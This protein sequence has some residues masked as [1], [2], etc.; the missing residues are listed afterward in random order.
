MDSADLQDESETAETVEV[1]IVAPSGAV[2]VTLPLSI[3]VPA[4][5]AMKTCLQ[6]SGK[7]AKGVFVFM[8]GSTL[9]EEGWCLEKVGV[10]AG[11]TIEVT[12][13][14]CLLTY[15]ERG[16]YLPE[17]N[18]SIS[19]GGHTFK[20][21]LIARHTDG[22]RTA[23]P[24]PRDTRCYLSFEPRRGRFA[25]L[26]VG[27][28]SCQLEQREYGWLYGQDENSWA[29]CF[30]PGEVSAR[31][32]GEA[33]AME[34]LSG[35]PIE[36]SALELLKHDLAPSSFSFLISATGQML[37]TLPGFDA[38]VVVPFEVP[39]D[40]DI[41]VVASTIE[42]G[43]RIS[44]SDAD[45]PWPKRGSHDHWKIIPSLRFHRWFSVHLCSS[46][47]TGDRGNS[48]RTPL[49]LLR[50]EVLRHQVTDLQDSIAAD[51]KQE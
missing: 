31:H 11:S 24:L 5:T 32:R 28:S 26:G 12:V 6:H 51:M 43:C 44:I 10:T 40:L 38:D 9:I 45:F 23:A 8:L 35:K 48:I 2:L 39:Q 37:M 3:R 25:C 29:L 15:C 18:N 47:P 19:N 34:D 30:G 21:G 13:L 27:T 22:V 36:D 4:V 46:L 14:D 33:Y 41:F 42:G 49:L 16:F 1:Q 20:R 17:F 7:Q 50:P